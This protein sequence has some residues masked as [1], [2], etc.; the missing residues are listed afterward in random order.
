MEV[1]TIIKK[2]VK[3]SESDIRK[4]IICLLYDAN[5][6]SEIGEVDPKSILFNATFDQEDF[7]EELTASV[8]IIKN[9]S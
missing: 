2:Q 6:I 7:I 4:A 5:E 3:I 9:G 1:T 8:E